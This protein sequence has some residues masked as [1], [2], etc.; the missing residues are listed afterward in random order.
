V[1][2]TA[3]FLLLLAQAG[4]A[5]TP[6][7]VYRLTL[8]AALSRATVELCV[9]RWPGPARL[10]SQ[11]KEAERFRSPARVTRGRAELVEGRRGISLRSVADGSCIEYDVNLDRLEREGGERALRRVG[12]SIF[13]SSGLWLWRPEND[14][15]GRELHIELR[16]PAGVEASVPWPPLARTADAALP[17]Y[18][19]TPTPGDWNDLTAFGELSSSELDVPGARLRLAIADTSPPANTADVAAWIDEAARAVGT[20]Y[21]RFPLPDVQV[22]IV[23]IGRRGEAVPW[24]QVQR[25]GS[26]AAHFYI[27]QY[28]PLTEFRDDWTATHELSHMLLPFV[29][30]RD[31]WLSEGFASYYQNVLRARAGMISP[32][33]AW[34]KLYAGFERGR[35]GT[36]GD[37]LAEV[38]RDMY[39]RGA[40][41]RVYWSGAAMALLADCC[42]P[43]YR[44][45]TAREV[46][47]RLDA[48]TA[49]DVFV[50]IYERYKHAPQ[51]PDV[52]VASAA[53]GILERDGRLRFES[54]PAATALRRAIMS[55]PAA[56]LAGS[57]D[58]D[59]SH[60]PETGSITRPG[61]SGSPRRAA[62]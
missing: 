51:F 48:L 10:L 18:R 47:T 19:L 20:L 27:D 7:A 54:T 41:M 29:S 5:A 57:P 45:W 38:S 36:R 42:L 16:L 11:Q 39:R 60:A 15:E 23:P 52:G 55:T 9:D 13:T 33:Q 37:T 53:L 61:D 22:V 2:P 34:E 6:D 58:T 31:A 62:P 24:A 12:D 25:G 35:R 14:D 26:A 46:L 50:G 30:R 40:F 8:D 56:L 32:D 21:G 1:T 43:S 4:A 44:T 49:T 59:T 17:R 28:R 3:L